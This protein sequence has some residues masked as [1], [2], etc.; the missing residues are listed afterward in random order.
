MTMRLSL[1]VLLVWVTEAAAAAR[2]EDLPIVFVT[3]SHAFMNRR[4]SNL[5]PRALDHIRRDVHL[6]YQTRYS[7][8][9]HHVIMADYSP[10]QVFE[11][12]C[13]NILRKKAS[14]VIYMSEL[15]STDYKSASAEFML[16][17]TNFVGL[18]TLVLAEDN[19]GIVQVSHGSNCNQIGAT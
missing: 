10:P 18:P 13:E 5:V 7:L 8:S 2:K 14:L 17:T 12:L 15:D 6:A 1:A 9:H 16:Q 11:I 19:S 3:K 4:Y